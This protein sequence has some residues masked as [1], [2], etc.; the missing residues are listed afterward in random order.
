VND[1]LLKRRLQ[2]LFEL[3]FY[4][5]FFAFFG[6]M[7]VTVPF[8][9][10]EMNKNLKTHERQILESSVNPSDCIVISP[11]TCHDFF[12]ENIS[13]EFEKQDWS[14]LDVQEME[15]DDLHSEEKM[16][17]LTKSIQH[18]LKI[19]LFLNNCIDFFQDEV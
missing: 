17:L 5:E 2:A 19:D 7:K 9:C 12:I 13:R 4:Y 8:F 15:P 3:P 1:P 16:G 18:E 11:I 6:R 10:K 14:I